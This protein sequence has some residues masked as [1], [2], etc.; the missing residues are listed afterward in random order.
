LALCKLWH[1]NENVQTEVVSLHR[2]V[3][4]TTYLKQDVSKSLTSEN[5]SIVNILSYL[6]TAAQKMYKHT[7]YHNI[8]CRT[9]ILN[10]KLPIQSS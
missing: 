1:T 2:D 5:G 10:L 8:C 6:E 7:V 3:N 4:I 9:E